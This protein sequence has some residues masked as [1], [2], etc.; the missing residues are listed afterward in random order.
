MDK[1]QQELVTF[2]I[3][4]IGLYDKEEEQKNPETKKTSHRYES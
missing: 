2:C 1:N 3:K 4:N